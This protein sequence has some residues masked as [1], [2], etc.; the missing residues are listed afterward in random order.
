MTSAKTYCTAV[1]ARI[2]CTRALGYL[3]DRL[4]DPDAIDWNATLDELAEGQDWDI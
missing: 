3:Q 1:T 4:P 2:S